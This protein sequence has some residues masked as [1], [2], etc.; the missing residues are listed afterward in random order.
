V[1]PLAKLAGVGL[2]VC[3]LLQ[4]APLIAPHLTLL[5]LVFAFAFLVSL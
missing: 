4:F 3:V 1:T 2:V 5:T